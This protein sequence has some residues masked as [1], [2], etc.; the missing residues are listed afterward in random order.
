M[1]LA[2]KTNFLKES[3]Q[4]IS[5]IE[6]FFLCR[7]EHIPE[8]SEKDRDIKVR[9]FLHDFIQFHQVLFSQSLNY[10]FSSILAHHGIFCQ[11]E[12]FLPVLV[13]LTTHTHDKL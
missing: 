10:F 8:N 13:I 1:T 12:Y 2:R 9:M 11:V 5:D 4:S 7:F 6:I 3:K